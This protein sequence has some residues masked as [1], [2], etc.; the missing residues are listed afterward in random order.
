MGRYLRSAG[1]SEGK[2]AAAM[3][4]AEEALKRARTQGIVTEGLTWGQ[5]IERLDTEP[6]E[7][8]TTLSKLGSVK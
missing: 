6:E 8:E 7:K 5:L 1:Q 2:V 4:I 3:Q